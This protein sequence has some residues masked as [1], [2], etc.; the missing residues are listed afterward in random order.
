M[1]PLRVH[2]VAVAD[3]L[4]RD[5]ETRRPVDATG[6]A[7]DPTDPTWARF[8]ADGDVAVEDTAIE[9]PHA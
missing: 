6:I 3:R 8:I 4:V 2:I 5:P 7:V 1:S 9:E